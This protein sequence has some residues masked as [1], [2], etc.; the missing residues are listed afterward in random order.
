M[1]IEPEPELRGFAADAAV[2]AA[3]SD[4]AMAAD[5]DADADA[6]KTAKKNAKRERERQRKVPLLLTGEAGQAPKSPTAEK[7][8]L[9]AATQRKSTGTSAC[10][11]LISE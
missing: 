3:S 7:T 10:R 2:P 8:A 4:A 5:G 6:A 9:V 11:L 1:S